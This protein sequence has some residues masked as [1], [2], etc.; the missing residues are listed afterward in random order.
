ME[1]PKN[2]KEAYGMTVAVDMKLSKG[3]M[4]QERSGSCGE[5]VKGCGRHGTTCWQIPLS[6]FPWASRSYG[7][8]GR[9]RHTTQVVKITSPKTWAKKELLRNL[10]V[11]SQLM[12]LERLAICKI[13]IPKSKYSEPRFLLLPKSKSN[14]LK[15]KTF[16]YRPIQ[17]RR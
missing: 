1:S 10:L 17:K 8:G 5:W 16:W 12:W 13:A 2:K 6:T 3:R 14:V 11:W 9:R 7:G 4:R 15:Y